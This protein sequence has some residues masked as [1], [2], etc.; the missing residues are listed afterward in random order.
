MSYVMC[1]A[2]A[3]VVGGAH[4]AVTL[5]VTFSADALF[6]APGETVAVDL[7]LRETVTDGSESLLVSEQG[8]ASAGASVVVDSGS[9][10]LPVAEL[11][12]GVMINEGV[13]FDSSD[14]IFGPVME[15]SST[16]GRWLTFARAQGATGELI[17]PGVRRLVLATLMFRVTG[18]EG[19]TCLIRAGDYDAATSDTTTWRSS[20]VL[21]ETLRYGGV[22]LTVIPGPGGLLGIA[23][24]G[25]GGLCAAP[26]R[27]V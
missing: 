13:F 6:V 11:L 20:S 2:L 15:Q 25:L 7:I 24:M 12:P 18:V 3:A 5:D 27:R 22:V 23:V 10:A 16:G 4:G 1:A 21:D 8:I 9:V 19:E 14:P 26:R 17:A